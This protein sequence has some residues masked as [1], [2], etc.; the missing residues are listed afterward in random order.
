MVGTVGIATEQVRAE[1]GG[2][3]ATIL[4]ASGRTLQDG[5]KAI[6]VQFEY[7]NNGS[8]PY[9]MACSFGVYAYQNDYELD[10][11]TN[12][13]ESPEE[14]DSAE[15][16]RAVRNGKSTIGSYEFAL[17][18]DVNDVVIEIV[19]PTA[20]MNVLA[21]KTYKLRANKKQKPKKTEEPELI[22]M[23]EPTMVVYEVLQVGD[24]GANVERLQIRLNEL[25]FDC[26]TPDGQY[27]NKTKNAV[28]EFQN[29]VNLQV[30]GIAD[31]ITQN[32]LYG[33]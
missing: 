20:D 3:V 2:C 12:V 15:L 1:Y 25:G 21:T 13:N 6:R 23:P 26:G 27:G 28:E 29:S 17:R 4:G 32:M 9:Y 24:K 19:T 14:G 8:T 18:D 22:S 30:T 7:V 11:V 10:N 5:R 33:K 16:V 31:S